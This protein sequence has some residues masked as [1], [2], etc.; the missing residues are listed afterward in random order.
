MPCSIFAL[1]IANKPEEKHG[2]RSVVL[3]NSSASQITSYSVPEKPY[4]MIT[5]SP[6]NPN[7]SSQRSRRTLRQ[8]HRVPEL[9]EQ[10]VHNVPEES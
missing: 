2:W 5:M 1:V 8:A 4:K 3:L 9:P 7:R 10:D 6:E